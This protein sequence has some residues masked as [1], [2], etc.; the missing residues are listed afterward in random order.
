MEGTTFGWVIHGGVDYAD[1]K[2]MYVREACDYKQL[3]S[4]DVLGVEDRG[5]DDQLEVL[6]EFQ[7]NV[8][9][10]PSGRARIYEYTPT[11]NLRSSYASGYEV[12]IPWIP[13][14]SLAN[15]NEQPS[16]R[17]LAGIERKL[18]QESELNEEYKKIDDDN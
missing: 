18:S 4:L 12:S 2:C 6:N 1:N 15:T 16:R 14:S 10:N 5:E 8:K 3:Y 7:E 13:G 17:R 11:P 9:R